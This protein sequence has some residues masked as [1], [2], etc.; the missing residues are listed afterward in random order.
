MPHYENQDKKLLV[1]LIRV[2]FVA[3]MLIVMLLYVLS[4]T[5]KAGDLEVSIA[6]RWW[7]P[8]LTALVLAGVFLAVDLL[9]PRKKISLISGVVF[10]LLA[11]LMTAWVFSVIID[12]VV[13][14]WDIQTDSIVSAVKVL[15]GVSCG[16]LGISMVLQTQDEFRLVIPYVEFAK[17]MRGPLPL[18]LDTSALI[19]ARIADIAASGLIQQT[20]VIPEFV[21][22]ELQLL[23]DSRDR[24]KRNKGRRGLD[25]ANK[26]QRMNGVD[27]MIDTT[28]TQKKAVDLALVELCMRMPAMLVTLDVALVRI[29]S[30]QNVLV[31]NLND[32]ANALKPV[33]IP[34]KMIHVELIKPGEQHGQAVGYL[35]DGTMVVAEDGYPYIGQTRDLVI[36][37]SMQTAAG[38]LLFARVDMAEMDTMDREQA[39][40]DHR[41]T[42]HHQEQQGGEG[43]YADEPAPEPENRA[44]D[45]AGGG[46]A[47]EEQP[48]QPKKPA[49]ISG[50]RVVDR[51]GSMKGTPRNPRR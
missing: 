44:E 11:G 8:V 9:T 6:Q 14:S 50:P 12:L 26:L 47:L 40:Q 20:V 18:V 43:D 38:R 15:I 31:L 35:E 25:I 10:G 7:I 2:G 33:V 28:P 13:Q 48:G 42:P 16:F 3:L 17:Q 24:M 34:G 1:R 22:E 49:T 27:V 37:S 4:I 51:P 45:G 19:D 21:L 39:I 46:D 29:S 32:L 23:A 30:I 41:P 5:S 36:T